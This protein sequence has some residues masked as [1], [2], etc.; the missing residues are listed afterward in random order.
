MELNNAVLLAYRRYFYRLEKFEALYEYFGKD[1][2]R[3]VAFLKE[4]H[5]S[6]EEPSSFLDRWMTEKG[7]TAP[8][9][10]Q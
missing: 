5:A 8:S 10:Q 2:K 7:V 9:F 6:K 3:V 1:L 4:I